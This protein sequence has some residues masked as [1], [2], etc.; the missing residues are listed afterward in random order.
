MATCSFNLC[1]NN[2]QTG[3]GQSAGW[4]TFNASSANDLI[5]GL[6]NGTTIASLHQDTRWVFRVNIDAVCQYGCDY[7]SDGQFKNV[8]HFKQSTQVDLDELNNR[9]LGKTVEVKV[10]ANC[11]RNGVTYDFPL[12]YFYK[13][14]FPLIVGNSFL[15]TSDKCL[16]EMPE[17][18]TGTFSCT[19]KPVNNKD[20]VDVKAYSFSIN[21]S[22]Q[23]S[24]LRSSSSTS[25][26]LITINGK[27]VTMN[28]FSSS[29]NLLIQPDSSH[30]SGTISFQIPTLFI[31]VFG[32]FMALRVEC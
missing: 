9:L 29:Y 22:V 7:Q 8:A 26:F 15:V 13:E 1:S 21:N 10:I 2:T 30:T 3:T 18:G 31:R 24:D 28:D 14:N 32:I 25:E 4:I 23:C 5:V 11:T 12:A 20:I 6:L 27:D 19:N 16:S 17:W